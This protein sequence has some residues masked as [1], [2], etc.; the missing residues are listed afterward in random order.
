MTLAMG[1][2]KVSLIQAQSPPS[3]DTGGISTGKGIY[4]AGVPELHMPLDKIGKMMNQR[5]NNNVTIQMNNPVFQDL[6]TQ[7]AYM[8]QIATVVAQ[9][10]APGAVAVDYHNDGITRKLMRGGG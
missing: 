3:F 2:A 7:Y 8:E 6:K 9:A 10:V 4:Y 5:P 1:M